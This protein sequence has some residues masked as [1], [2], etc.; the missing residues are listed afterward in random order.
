MDLSLSDFCADK[1]YQ[2]FELVGEGA[3]GIV[4]SAI[5]NTSQF[6]VAMKRIAP[7]DHSMFCLQALR[8]IKLLRH[9][10]HENIIPILQPPSFDQFQFMIREVYLIQELMKTDL[11]PVI[12]CT[13]Q[14]SDDHCQY[15]I[16]Q[17]LEL[18]HDW[19]SI[20]LDVLSA[21]SIDDFYTISSQRSREYIRAL[22]FR[23]SKPFSQLSPATNA[24]DV[25]EKCLTF[26]PR[27][28]IIVVKALQH[29]YFEPYHDPND[30]P[31][32]DPID[33]SFDFNNGEALEQEDLK[34]LIYKEITNAQASQPSLLLAPNA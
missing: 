22:P 27:R 31:M 18:G 34:V 19:L 32:A 8:E 17:V 2:V 29:P 11:H 21:P 7:F 9:F 30:E 6:K 25:L 20:I 5:C 28:P 33:P 4:C 1:S 16:Y 24:M 23:K 10:R 14:L 15:F 26:S 3:H 13:Q 12:V